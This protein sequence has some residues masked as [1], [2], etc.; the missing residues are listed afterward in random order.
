MCWY[1]LKRVRTRFIYTYV[2]GYARTSRTSSLEPPTSQSLL[3]KNRHVCLLSVYT[4][5]DQLDL[6]I[7]RLKPRKITRLRRLHCIRTENPN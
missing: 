3:D 7:R 1:M 2:H 6:L 5:S 4:L